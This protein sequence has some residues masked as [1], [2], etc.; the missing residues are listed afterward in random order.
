[1]GIGA[2]VSL[3]TDGRLVGFDELSMNG[4][5]SGSHPPIAHFGLGKR[6][7]VEVRVRFPARLEPLKQVVTAN[8]LVTIKEQ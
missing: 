2:Q 8:Q 1:M 7:E 6:Q 5:Y 3:Y 4:G